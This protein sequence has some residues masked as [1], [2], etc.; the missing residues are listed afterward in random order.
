MIGDKYMVI[1][2]PDGVNI[3]EKIGDIYVEVV[4]KFNIPEDQAR[5]EGPDSIKFTIRKDTK[6]CICGCK[7]E[8]APLSPAMKILLGEKDV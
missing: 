7:M 5:L 2:L 1:E 3:S 8:V 6:K 4:S